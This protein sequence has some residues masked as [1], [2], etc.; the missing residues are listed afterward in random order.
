MPNGLEVVK[1]KLPSTALITDA[2]FEG[3]D[4]VLYTKSKA[5]FLEGDE[6]VRQLVSELRKRIEIRPDEAIRLKQSEAKQKVLEIVPKEAEVKDIWFEPEFGRV[7]IFASKPGLVIGK[8]GETLRTIKKETLWSPLVQR[9][10]LFASPIVNRAREIVHEEAGYRVKFLN[11]IGEKIQLKKGAKEG[12][13]RVSFLGS[14]RE[15]GRSCLLLQTKESRVLLDCGLGVGMANGM[16]FIDAPEVNIETLDA[17]II[18]H[19]HLDHC[20]F[21]PALYEHGFKGP[22]YSTAPTR[23]VMTLLCLDYVD[24]A[25]RET[26]KPIYTSEGI[27]DMIKHSVTLDFGEVTDITPDMRLTFQPAGH[28]LGSALSHLHIGEGLHNVLYSADWATPTVVVDST[29]AVQVVEIGRFIDEQLAKYGSTERRGDVER[30][31]NLEGW[32]TVA[33]DP[34]TYRLRVAPITSFLRH[35]VRERLYRIETETGRIV[36]VTA[37]HS[38]FTAQGGTVRTKAVEELEVGDWIIGPK[39]A[40]IPEK[41]PIVN[42]RPFAGKLRISYA[43]K[44]AR[45]LAA[46]YQA[47]SSKERA[48]VV[49]HFR[50]LYLQDIARRHHV[51]VKT[52]RRLFNR[53]GL[54]RWSMVG[55]S[56]PAE[57]EI[58]P[59]L[60]RFLGYWVA[61]GSLRRHSQTVAISNYNKAI[62]KDAAT[63]AKRVFGLRGDLR[64]HDLL[65]HSKQLAILLKDVLGCGKDAYTKRVPKPILSAPRDVVGQFLHGY[66]RGDGCMITRS[67]G[68][69]V[70]ASSKSEFLLHDINLL[71]L[72]FGLRPSPRYNKT[73]RMWTLK[74]HQH[75]K[76]EE[77][78]QLTRLPDW[79]KG[80]PP[81]QK[82]RSPISERLPI[83]ALSIAAQERLART[84]YQT[85]ISGGAQHLS[86]LLGE[87][88]CSETDYRLRDSDFVFE[89]VK[90]IERVAPTNGY[91]YDFEISGFENFPGGW[92]FLHNTSDMK[93]APTWLFE[94]ASTNFARVETLIMESTYG[95]PRD[96]MPTRRDADNKLLRVINDTI[97]RRGKVI[98]PCFAIGRSQEIIIALAEAKEAGLFDAPVFLDGMIWE[99]TAIHTTYPEYLSNTLQRKIFHQGWN[100]F[101]LSIFKQVKGPTERKSVIDSADPCVIL[102]TSGMITGGPVMEY[103]RQLGGDP[104]NS[105]IF[106]G[107]QSEGTLGSK[108]QRGWREIP[109]A[110][111]EEDRRNMLKLET[112]VHTVEGY[113]G[114]SDRNQLLNFVS[115][116]KTKPERVLLNHG[117]VTK[118]VSL[119]RSV[120]NIFKLETLVPHNL[121]AVRLR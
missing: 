121:D 41:K 90:R 62:L 113:S 80:L 75:D 1:A 43:Q 86:L 4:I 33:F 97:K 45:Q 2:L 10:P 59:D 118:S 94:P 83:E 103:L 34:K 26:G 69:D 23:D 18:G 119:A 31:M 105:I 74:L 104:K 114:H 21:L 17:V 12:W 57:L 101:S 19:S 35:P 88:T 93:F 120:H 96:V 27:K 30:L 9:V 98:I 78:L 48:W 61:E 68:S 3:S 95:G 58:T 49:D 55:N 82:I 89:R 107:Y 99:A 20:G 109:L 92:L 47:L 84:S 15:I 8:A 70:Q 117:E 85:A 79:A 63:I 39:S 37:S 54:S 40:P 36:A 53:L 29:G 22:V 115:R 72:R 38:V 112:E 6:R 13:V 32:Q 64:E 60:A 111:T 102:T 91:V 87:E 52:V 11:K 71:L 108:I 42:L 76:I 24:I 65:L 16:P 73:A 50:G 46:R 28:I 110:A 66:Y 106:V 77:F 67:Y 7:V 25:Q 56:L 51:S 100:P 14:A 5:F 81:R 116:L 44:E